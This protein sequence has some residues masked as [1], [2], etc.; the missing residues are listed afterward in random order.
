MEKQIQA[1]TMLHQTKQKLFK[2]TAQRSSIV[3]K[4]EKEVITLDITAPL[5]DWSGRFTIHMRTLGHQ[6][7]VGV[8]QVKRLICTL[9]E[10]REKFLE[11]RR[12]LLQ[13][14]NK[15]EE[16]GVRTTST[17]Q[18]RYVLSVALEIV[19]SICVTFIR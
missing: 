12:E 16:E 10:E 14:I 15:L 11:E 13:K 19:A 2:E 18:H 9:T 6:E 1:K 4:L 8:F 7:C 5:L 3:Q 17:V